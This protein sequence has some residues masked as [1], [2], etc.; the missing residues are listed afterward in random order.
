MVYGHPVL[1]GPPLQLDAGEVAETV[2]KVGGEDEVTH[3]LVKRPEAT[4]DGLRA[5]ILGRI[6]RD[7]QAAVTQADTECL[8]QIDELGG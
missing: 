8:D 6:E 5:Q 4:T 2:A 7:L 1:T 3:L